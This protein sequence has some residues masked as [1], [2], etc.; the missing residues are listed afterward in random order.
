MNSGLDAL[1]RASATMFTASS[2][3]FSRR[4]SDAVRPSCD[5]RNEQH[6]P[7]AQ[8]GQRQLVSARAAGA[9]AAAATRSP[10]PVQRPQTYA[11]GGLQ[12]CAA[13]DE[14]LH[15]LDLA[16]E[17]RDGDRRHAILHSQTRCRFMEARLSPRQV[18]A[19]M[20]ATRT[21][22]KLQLRRR[23]HRPCRQAVA[24]QA[25]GPARR[26]TL[27][28]ASRSAPL[29]R[30]RSMTATCPYRDAM[31]RGVSA[32]CGSRMAQACGSAG[33]AV[34]RARARA[35]VRHFSSRP[36]TR[37]SPR[38]KRGRAAA[39]LRWETNEPGPWPRCWRRSPAAPPRSQPRPWPKRCEAASS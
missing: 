38:S 34:R 32:S 23:A 37:S 9:A 19:R 20:R 15:C 17:R 1:S 29:S 12:V 22:C 31:V 27:S 36:A 7:R 30:S 2:P 25:T 13:H 4:T 33:L 3:S 18:E 11:V 28:W 35:A 16:A 14:R 24:R 21:T 39:D 8:L 26:L 10:R 6:R 5:E